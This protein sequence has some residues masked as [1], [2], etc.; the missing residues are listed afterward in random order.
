MWY[1]DEVCLLFFFKYL[2]ETPMHK[3][4][5]IWL[6]KEKNSIQ[7]SFLLLLLCGKKRISVKNTILHVI[8]YNV[9]TQL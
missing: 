5:F 1:D 6:K 3:V 7:K 4:F 8:Y 9:L 2:L